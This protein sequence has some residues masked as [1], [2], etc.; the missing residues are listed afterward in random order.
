MFDQ[1]FNQVKEDRQG[2]TLTYCLLVYAER[3]CHVRLRREKKEWAKK[4]GKKWYHE[5]SF[6]KIDREKKLTLSRAR[7]YQRGR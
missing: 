7:K 1:A 2:E 6:R 5:R 3:R 4:K